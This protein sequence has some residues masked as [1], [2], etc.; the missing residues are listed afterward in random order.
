MKLKDLK[1][2]ITIII[3]IVCIM[4]MGFFIYRTFFYYQSS[5]EERWDDARS[6]D[7]YTIDRETL[8]NTTL[9]GDEINQFNNIHSKRKINTKMQAVWVAQEVEKVIYG[10]CNITEQPFIVKFNEN[11][12]AWIVH[13][14]A[15]KMVKK[16]WVGGVITVAIDKETGSIL[17]VQHT[18]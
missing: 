15:Y 6:F 13:G 4:A 16:G 11:A 10:D 18:N 1:R 17:H 14:N 5:I 8:I 12:E 3:V 7:F 9:A 2:V